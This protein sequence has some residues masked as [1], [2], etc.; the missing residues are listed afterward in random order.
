[1]KLKEFLKSYNLEKAREIEETKDRQFIAL[2][3]NWEKI[4]SITDIKKIETYKV[5]Y[6]YMIIQTA[7]ISFQLS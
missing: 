7:L 6:L 1:M 2:K 4:D 3:K 5:N